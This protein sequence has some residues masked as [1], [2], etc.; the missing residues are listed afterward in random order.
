MHPTSQAPEEKE[1]QVV[2]AGAKDPAKDKAE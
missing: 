1:E 2:P